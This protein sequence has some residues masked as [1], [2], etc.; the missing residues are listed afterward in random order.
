MKLPV[1]Y[2]QYS[3]MTFL[4]S[5]N[6]RKFKMKR[7]KGYNIKFWIARDFYYKR[8]EKIFLS[9]LFRDII[10]NDSIFKL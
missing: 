7:Y 8:F 5:Q 6:T 9:N 1:A 4:L 10:I 3:F 2:R